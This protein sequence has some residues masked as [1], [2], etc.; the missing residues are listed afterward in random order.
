MEWLLSHL[1]CLLTL[2]PVSVGLWF[3]LDFI[4]FCLPSPPPPP[5]P[6]PN[7]RSHGLFL[8]RLLPVSGSVHLLF[9][10][11]KLHPSSSQSR[12]HPHCVTSTHGRPRPTNRQ[13]RLSKGLCSPPQLLV[14][15]QDTCWFP[16]QNLPHP[17]INSFQMTVAN[18]TAWGPSTR[19]TA[20]EVPLIPG[21]SVIS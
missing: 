11:R 5:A 3:L 19:Q 7:L 8:I 14:P 20:G 9:L 1:H 18:T 21:Y 6:A 17:V 12:Q 4:F 16:L 13:T 2:C 15:C 10:F